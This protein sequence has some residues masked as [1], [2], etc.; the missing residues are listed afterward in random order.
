MKKNIRIFIYTL[1]ILTGIVW[2]C[3][4]LGD[5]RPRDRFAEEDVWASKSNAMG[6]VYGT[7]GG[8]LQGLYTSQ[9]GTERW[10]NNLIATAGTAFTREEISRDDDYGFNQFGYIRRCNMIIEKSAASATIPDADKAELQAHGKFLRAMTYYWL[11]RRFG[12]VVF[13]DKVLTENET[14]YALPQTATIAET[15]T[16]IMKDIDA[17][18][19]GLPVTAPSGLASK[20]TA[21]ALKSEV[22][23]QAAAYTGDNSYYQKA[24]DAA[25]SVIQKGGF[26]LETDYE[27]LF[28]EK[29]RTSPEIILAFYRD[30][31]NTTCDNTDMQQII[32][33]TNNDNVRLR[34]A[35]PEFKVD[36]MF[37]AWAQYS[38]TQSIMDAYL[39]IDAADP[40]KA[41]RWDQS[42]QYLANITKRASGFADSAVVTGAGS[43]NSIIYNNRDKRLAASIVYDSV[44]WYGETVTTNR[45][46]NLHR[47]INGSLS[48]GCCMPVT[49]C[50]VRKGTYSVSPRPFVGIPTDYHWVILRLGR[51]YLNKAEALLRLNRVSEAVAAFNMTRV[52][53]GGLPPSTAATATAAWTD[54]KRE[55]RVDLFEEQDYYWSLLRWGKYGGAAN[56]GIAAGGT[57][58]ELEEA[59]TYLEINRDRN[60]YRIEVLNW[61]QNQ[62]RVFDESRRYLLPIQNAQ[63]IRHGSLEQ[64]P[65]W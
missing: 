54:Y 56:S 46:G 25:D 16:L 44:Q 31:S 36:K 59:P 50:F 63:I 7:Y 1:I 22:A 53:H 12:R 24:L 3:K 34:G 57:I 23:L 29:K 48:S 13:V 10:T 11:A 28:N 33:N 4:K 43:I 47:L 18:I 41:V 37:E 21:Y 51:V 39:A 2:S 35:T 5:S 58:P 38:P 6:F 40:T 52:T 60:G 9:I 45:N 14:D 65:N 64:N 62:I 19:A 20:W 26:S 42:S 15:Y 55:R 17:A 30:K 27:G 49:N 61:T 8:I 32:P